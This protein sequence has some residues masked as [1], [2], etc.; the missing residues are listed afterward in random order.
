M[1][2]LLIFMMPKDSITFF[3]IV[4]S[5]NGKYIYIISG[6][7]T[8]KDISSPLEYINFIHEE[9][10]E[11]IGIF[12]LEEGID[13]KEDALM[14]DLKNFKTE[15]D[16]SLAGKDIGSIYINTTSGFGL[17]RVALSVYML[18]E[19]PDDYNLHSI[20]LSE[21]GKYYVNYNYKDNFELKSYDIS[22]KYIGEAVDNYLF[23]VK[24]RGLEYNKVSFKSVNTKMNTLIDN[25]L[26]ESSSYRLYFRDY[27]KLEE[28]EKK[29]IEEVIKNLNSK[30][31]SSKIFE[32]LVPCLILRNIKNFDEIYFYR[33]IKLNTENDNERKKLEIDIGILNKKADFFSIEVTTGSK[34]M[35]DLKSRIKTLKDNF[36][37]KVKIYLILPFISSEL[38]LI[39]LSL[40]Q[41][42]KIKLIQDKARTQVKEHLRELKIEIKD[43]AE[44]I[45]DYNSKWKQFFENF[46]LLD[47]NRDIKIVALDKID[48]IIKFL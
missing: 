47:L 46:Y 44:N 24:N 45:P 32:E 36:G 31:I 41:T 33:N 8:K 23:K 40:E 48:E 20:Y 12:Q 38:S 42:L 22:I 3:K 21:R 6:K 25:L 2:E 5:F 28:S 30:L 37:A 7:N 14:D 34:R 11:L 4:K 35:K 29:A 43:I 10:K 15:L 13:S 1:G 27:N 16:K 26:E 9:G 39:K 19:Y 17:Y 18:K